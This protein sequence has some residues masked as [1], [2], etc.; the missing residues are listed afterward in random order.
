MLAGDPLLHL[1]LRQVSTPGVTLGRP[2]T[3]G[4]DLLVGRPVGAQAP[5]NAVAAVG[6]TN[7]TRGAHATE[8]A[9][10]VARL[11]TRTIRR[12]PAQHLARRIAADALPVGLRC[13]T[14]LCWTKENIYW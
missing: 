3:R 7:Q 8:G 13:A 1:A 11:D 6:R 5:R 10:E 2:G 14:L 9:A 12:R 4:V